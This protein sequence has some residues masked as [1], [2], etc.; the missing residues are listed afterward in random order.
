[1][2]LHRNF[3]RLCLT[4][5]SAPLF[6]ACW[7]LSSGIPFVHYDVTSLPADAP[8]LP[9]EPTNHGDS[10]QAVVLRMRYKSGLITASFISPPAFEGKMSTHY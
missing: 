5:Y 3:C 8:P 6:M 9:G 1:M 10:R 7:G 4:D 2:F